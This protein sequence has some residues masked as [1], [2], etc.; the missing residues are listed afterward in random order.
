[1]IEECRFG[2]NDLSAVELGATAG[3]P[4]FNMP[5][6]LGLFRLGGKPNR[7]F[8]KNRAFKAQRNSC[9]ILKE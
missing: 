6:E 3:L 5:F 9:R 8:P 7:K 1:M 4:R 2:I